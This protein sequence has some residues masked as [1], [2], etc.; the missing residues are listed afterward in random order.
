MGRWGYLFFSKEIAQLEA[1]KAT[2]TDPADI[3]EVDAQI[4]DLRA[5]EAKAKASE[6]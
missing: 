4:A 6:E 2:L 5:K 3:A 1:F